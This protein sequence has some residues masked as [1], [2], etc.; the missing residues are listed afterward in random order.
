MLLCKSS[1][2]VIIL[3]GEH[4]SPQNQA[5]VKVFRVVE[6]EKVYLHMFRD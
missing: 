1:T 6:T 2:I 5:T 4:Y 3:S